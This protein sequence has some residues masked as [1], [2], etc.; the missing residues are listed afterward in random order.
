MIIWRSCVQS[1]LAAACGFQITGIENTFW[2]FL[3]LC[4]CPWS[5]FGLCWWWSPI[6]LFAG[7]CIGCKSQHS[8]VVPPETILGSEPCS[9]YHLLNL[10][11]SSLILVLF[12][13][14]TYSI[15]SLPIQGPTI[16]C[17]SSNLLSSIHDIASSLFLHMWAW[18]SPVA[19]KIDSEP[20]RVMSAMHR[21]WFR[22]YS[23]QWAA[24]LSF[25]SPSNPKVPLTTS[26]W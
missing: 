22:R 25:R 3:R 15:S 23:K 2:L 24:W 5:I 19:S 6:S 18:P 10:E 7:T 14:F 13:I 20:S 12:W 21:I 11:R 26:W 17:I 1:T 9:R 8:V 4:A 16:L